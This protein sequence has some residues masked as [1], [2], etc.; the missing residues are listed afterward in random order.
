MIRKTVLF[1]AITAAFTLIPATASAD[2]PLCPQAQATT[3][4]PQPALDHGPFF[5]AV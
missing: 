4:V 2:Q 5:C 3:V 1:A